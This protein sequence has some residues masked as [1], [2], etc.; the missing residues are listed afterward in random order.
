MSTSETQSPD[1]SSPHPAAA[2]PAFTEQ[3]L[4]QYS[5]ERGKRMYIAHAGIVYDVTDCP[6]WQRGI[7]ENLHWPGQ[8]LTGEIADAPHTASVF[9]HPC[10]RRVGVLKA[11]A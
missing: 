1:A 8:D 5:G 7:H 2:E 4:R 10:A 3:Q 6:K 11:A 9:D